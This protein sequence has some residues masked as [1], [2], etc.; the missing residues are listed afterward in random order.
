MSTRCGAAWQRVA[1]RHPIMRTRFRWAGVDEPVQEVVDARRRAARR[2]RPRAPDPDRAGRPARRVPGRRPP[3]AAS[4]STPHRCGASTCSG[5]ARLTSAFVFTYHHSLLDTSVVWMTEEAFRTYDALR[6][7]EVAE[8][9]ERRPYKDHIEWLHDAPGCGSR[10]RPGLLR[11]LLD[12]FDEPT[13]LASLEGAT[14][15]ASTTSP[16][17]VRRA[18]G[19]ALAD[20][21]SARFHAFTR[22]PPRQRR[23]ARR[24]GVG[25]VLAAFSGT[26]DVVFGSTRG[27]RRSGLP[28]SE[29]VMGLFINTPPVR[30]TI[31]AGGA[32][33]R[34][35]RC[36]ARPAGRQAGPR[37]HRAVRHPGHHRR[38]G[39]RA[40]VRH[41][42]RHQRAA[43][44][45]PPEGARAAR[46]RRA[47]STSTTRRTSR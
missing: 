25:L 30:V 16:T 26:T 40:A 11:E 9:V 5:S 24:G 35:A 10:R 46:S 47:T 28:G 6:R 18:S 32:R 21:V 27:C 8:L 31:D 23:G 1:D 41:H 3:R 44:G 4:S 34:P 38:P 36:G 17:S 43:P 22:G 45:H 12:G 37:A 42:R 2:A 15:A 13:R 20:D 19:S 14:D 29:D 7:G 33:D 39:R